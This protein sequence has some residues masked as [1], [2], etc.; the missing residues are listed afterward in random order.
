[1][2]GH[3]RHDS[4]TFL[5]ALAAITSLVGS[6]HGA[7]AAETAPPPPVELTAE[8]VSSQWIT[9]LDYD[10]PEGHFGMNLVFRVVDASRFSVL[11]KDKLGRSWWALAVRDGE[12][13][14]MDLRNETHCRYSSAVRIEAIPLGPLDFDLIPQFIL[15]HLPFQPARSFARGEGEWSLQDQT[16]R[17]WFARVGEAGALQSWRLVGDGGAPRLWWSRTD[18]TQVFSAPEQE[19]QL[20]WKNSRLRALEGEPRPLTVPSESVEDC[21]AR[22]FFSP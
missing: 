19:L 6:W 3:C 2:T 10:G 1:M 20:R 12:A 16:E 17:T 11:A 4:S 9:D 5:V 7:A 14:A 13:L 15:G 21:Q 18:R 8:Q 22:S